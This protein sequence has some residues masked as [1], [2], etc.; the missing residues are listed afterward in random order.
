MRD[1]RL[2][3]DARGRAMAAYVYILA[4]RRNGTLYIGVTNNLRRRVSEHRDGVVA[5]FT[6]RYGLKMLVYFEEHESI[7]AAIQREKTMKHWVRRWKLNVI[8]RDN[9]DWRNLWHD[10]GSA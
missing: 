2:P 9:P 5:G 8:E 7:I 4:S 3:L 10:V 6:R 1:W